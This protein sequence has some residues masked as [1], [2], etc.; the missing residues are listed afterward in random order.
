[1]SGSRPMSLRKETW[2]DRC[3]RWSQS[4][5]LGWLWRCYIC[6]LEAT[7]PKPTLVDG[8]TDALEH[9]ADEHLAEGLRR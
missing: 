8:Y 5:P 7:Y 6:D 9:L 2:R 4:G 3:W 1:M